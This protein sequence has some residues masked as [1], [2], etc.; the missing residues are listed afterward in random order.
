M[1]ARKLQER[2]DR[3]TT[4]IT[5]RS[6]LQGLGLGTLSL[7]LPVWSP[8]E[9]QAQS[10]APTQRFFAFFTPNGTVRNDFFPARGAAVTSSPILSPL[11]AFEDRLLVLKSVN[12][13]SMVGDNK[14]GDPI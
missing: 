7:A 11:Q 4:P 2:A 14:P 5:R 8:L 1:H 6:V 13:D 3:L 9:A 12:M 10:A